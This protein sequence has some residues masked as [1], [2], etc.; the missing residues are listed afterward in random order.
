MCAY[1]C[2]PRSPAQRTVGGATSGAQGAPTSGAGGGDRRGQIPHM[3]P[4]TEC[5]AKV[6]TR[7]VPGHWEGDLINGVRN[8]RPSGFW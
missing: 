4:M 1:M 8:G 7:T 6:A 2:C 3:T 5:P